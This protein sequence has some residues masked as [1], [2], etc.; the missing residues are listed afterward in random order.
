[1]CIDMYFCFLEN[2]FILFMS[3]FFLKKFIWDLYGYV[4]I[5]VVKMIVSIEFVLFNICSI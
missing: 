4:F 5:C 1:M 3:F 2:C